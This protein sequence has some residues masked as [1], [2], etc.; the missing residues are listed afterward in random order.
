MDLVTREVE[1]HALDQ[2][3]I[4]YQDGSLRGRVRPGLRGEGAGGQS[5]LV[6]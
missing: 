2:T 6:K 4:N 3:H 1:G 5:I